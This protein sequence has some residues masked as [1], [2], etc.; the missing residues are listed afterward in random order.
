MVS[1]FTDVGHIVGDWDYGEDKMEKWSR[2]EWISV[3]DIA[4]KY[5]NVY[6]DFFKWLNIDDFDYTPRA[7]ESIEDQ[8]K[9]I[10]KL[11]EKGY[12]YIVPEDGIYM[13]TSKI[14]DY[15]KLLGANYKKALAWIQAGERIDMW[16]KK[17]PTDFA[18]RKFSPK[19]EKRQMERESPWGI[20]FPGRHSECCVMSSNHLWHQFDIHHGWVDMIPVH[21]TNEIAQSEIVFSVHPRVKYWIHHEFVLMNWKKMWKSDWNWVDPFE[22]LEKWYD[23]PD[24]RYRFF[25]TQYRSFLDFTRDGIQQIQNARKSLI[26]KIGDDISTAQ[27]FIKEKSFADIEK[28]LHTDEG[29]KFRTE[30]SEAICDDFN[31]PKFLSIVNIYLA[32][33][34]DEIRSMIYRLEIHFLKIWL[35]QKIV[36]EK[37]NIPVEVTTLADQRVQAKQEK[38][39]ALSD[40]LRKKITDLWREIKDTKEGYEI[41]KL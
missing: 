29:K 3:R 6:R 8:I 11:E 25:S 30:I 38:N 23:Y 10:Q 15:G 4:K 13:D 17:N 7:T 22:L 27:L 40:E 32:Q 1:N 33:A 20:W 21:H 9:F 35:F 31:T 34:N 19:T 16:W 37:F 5:E 39:Y 24:I 14:P 2:I 41:T 12:T 28:K 18:L 36:E 26:K